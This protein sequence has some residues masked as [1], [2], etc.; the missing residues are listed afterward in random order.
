MTSQR[1]AGV[2]ASPLRHICC[3]KGPI[4]S[5]PFRPS[6]LKVT[7]IEDDALSEVR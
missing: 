4:G 3:R 1:T 2:F 5:G 6:V 7:R